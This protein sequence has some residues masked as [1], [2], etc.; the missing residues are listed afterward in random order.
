[1]ITVLK[2]ETKKVSCLSFKMF[3]FFQFKKSLSFILAWIIVKNISNI[4]LIY[5]KVLEI[6]AKANLN[7][8][9]NFYSPWNH[10]N[11]CFSDDFRTD[12]LI[13][14]GIE[15]LLNIRSKIWRRFF[16]TLNI[17]SKYKPEQILCNKMS[18]KIKTHQVCN[19]SI[20]GYLHQT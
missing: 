16:T 11:L 19:Y 1:M 18:H 7:K 3:C 15:F 4:S 2:K 6:T 17:S 8:L 20:S 13:S 14:G 12:F 9:I 10:K 5:H